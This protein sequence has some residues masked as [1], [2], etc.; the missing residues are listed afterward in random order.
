M[1]QWFIKCSHELLKS[2]INPVTSPN[3]SIVTRSRDSILN[4]IVQF[5]GGKQPLVCSNCYRTVHN[6][7]RWFMEICRTMSFA[8]C[9]IRPWWWG[10]MNLEISVICN[11]L[12][13]LIVRE[14]FINFS[15]HEKLQILH[16]VSA[17][18]RKW[19]ISPKPLRAVSWMY[20]RNCVVAAEM[21][22]VKHTFLSYKAFSAR[23]WILSFTKIFQ[24][25]I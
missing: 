21:R 7:D 22:Q 6:I 8:T 1:W 2:S 17:K 13:Q 14:D 10:K 3:L 20:Y 4:F 18:P 16:N 11:Q 23:V 12:T 25:V 15:H 5:E 24:T 19:N 9:D